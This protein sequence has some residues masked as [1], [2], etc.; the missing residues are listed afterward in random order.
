[1]FVGVEGVENAIQEGVGMGGRGFEVAIE[2]EE[3]GKEREDEGK[4]YLG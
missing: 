1:M 2:L 4:R 3:L